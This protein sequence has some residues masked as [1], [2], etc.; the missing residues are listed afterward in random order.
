[1]PPK[2]KSV[3]L[4]ASRRE[5]GPDNGIKFSLMRAGVFGRSQPGSVLIQDHMNRDR[6]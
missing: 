4:E 3:R 1:M 2:R 6:A 5:S